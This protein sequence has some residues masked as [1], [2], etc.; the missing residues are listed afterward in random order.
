MKHVLA[1]AAAAWMTLG[2]A[3][4]ADDE[5]LARA[6]D[7]YL[8]ASY[9]EALALLDGL[10]SGA[11][12]QPLQVA[13]YRVF[14]LLALNRRAEALRA[15]ESVVKAN[16]FYQPSEAVASPRIR[17]VFVEVRRGLM[18]SIIHSAYVE[19]KT[20]FD[21]KDPRAT[22][23]FEH[24]LDLL[25]DADVAA[26]MSD[27]RTVAVGFRDLSLA[28]AVVPATPTSVDSAPTA[29]SATRE[30]VVSSE[31]AEAA[32]PSAPPPPVSTDR[33]IG[34][35]PPEA[36]FQ[37]MPPWTPEGAAET[38]QTFRGSLELAI[39]ENGTVVTAKMR[40]SAHPRYDDVLV[41]AAVRWR[42]KPARRDGMAIP[43]LR[44]VEIELRPTR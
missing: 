1:F 25:A 11:V 2:T 36:V 26:T 41:K 43:Y 15:I 44:V 12:Q 22:A 23:L 18:S 13:E 19:A 27:L 30:A 42:F 31:A 16:P 20:A 9:D 6:K 21:R 39:D 32:N 37:P 8:S 4:A 10:A 7:L 38:T 33:D 35:I 17:S 28:A 40:K 24:V 5:V 29:S 3:W 34:V 14:C